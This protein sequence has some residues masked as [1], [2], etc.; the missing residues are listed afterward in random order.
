MEKMLEA[1][2]GLIADARSETK[3]DKSSTDG[4]ILVA[5]NAELRRRVEELERRAKEAAAES[6]MDDARVS[7]GVRVSVRQDQEQHAH[8]RVVPARLATFC[9]LRID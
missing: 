7:Q 1:M 9:V 8:A 5:E 3:G 4:A 2:S 6:S